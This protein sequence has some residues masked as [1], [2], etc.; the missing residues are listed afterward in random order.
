M[1]WMKVFKTK[2]LRSQRNGKDNAKIKYWQ[3]VASR[4]LTTG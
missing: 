4:R 3:L 2:V 1:N